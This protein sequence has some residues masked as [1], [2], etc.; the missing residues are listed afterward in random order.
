MLRLVVC[1]S[2]INGLVNETKCTLNKFTGVIE[3]GGAMVAPFGCG[4]IQKNLSRLEKWDNLDLMKT[5]K[6]N[7]EPCTQ[8]GTIPHAGHAGHA[9]V[10]T[11]G[12]QLGKEG[13]V[14]P[15]EHQADHEQMVH[16][17]GKPGCWFPQLQWAE[18]VQ[19]GQGGD[20]APVLSSGDTSGVLCTTLCFPEQDRH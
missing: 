8:G 14:G 19:Q 4:A 2:L 11:V 13:P 7:S 17:G 3:L 15:V 18:G 10:H 5:L 12:K 9:G 16:S 20:P 6:G 1:S